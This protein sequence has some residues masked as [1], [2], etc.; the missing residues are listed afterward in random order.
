MKS[1]EE[2]LIVVFICLLTISCTSKSLRSESDVI[3]INLFQD[4]QE[5]EIDL[6]DIADIQYISMDVD[7]NYLFKGSPRYLSEIL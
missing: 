6:N 7:E 1:L 4:Y 5:R 2:L 3:R